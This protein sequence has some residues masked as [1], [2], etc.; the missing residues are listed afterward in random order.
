MLKMTKK[1]EIIKILFKDYLASYNSR[2]ISKK[3]GIS[4]AGAFKIFK[5]MEKEE[6]VKPKRIGN[7]VIYSLNLQNPIA[8]RE[9]EMALTIESQIY[10]RWIEEFSQIKDKV[11]FVILFGSVIKKDDFNDIDLL[12]VTEKKD[13]K[14]I[15]KV[16]NEKNKILTKKIHPIFQTLKDFENDIT[17]KNKVLLEIIKTGIVIFGQGEITKIM[18]DFLR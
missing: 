4:H 7:A 6:I 11:R 8:L 14:E 18:G 2:T 3:I 16:I 12:I 13:I 17:K 9:I 15:K 5:K 1:M 10:K